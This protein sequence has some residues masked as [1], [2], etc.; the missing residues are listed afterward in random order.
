M[1]GSNCLSQLVVD[2]GNDTAVCEDV[3]V[4]RI[5]G[6]PTAKGGVPPYTY[7]WS[8]SYN[9]S[10]LVF[11]ASFMLED[12]TV[13]NPVFKERAIPESVV[14]YVTV[15]D[16]NDSVAIDSI[17]VRQTIFGACLGECRHYINLGD[18]V[19]LGH[20]VW[21]G[22]PPMHY[23]WIPTE[24]LSDSSLENPWAKPTAYITNYTLEITDSIGCQ[25]WSFCR[26]YTHTLNHQIKEEQSNIH[27]YP[28]PSSH[29]IFI[30]FN[31]TNFLNTSFE[32]NSMTGKTICIMEVYEPIISFETQDFTPGAYVYK[33]QSYNKLIE[34]GVIIIE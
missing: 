3:V 19:Q 12:T 13:A 20:C 9:I 26:V 16:A 32:I 34:T 30:E 2:A 18:S 4:L 5:G 11:T 22:I 10:Y 8:G 7:S 15:R 33:W 29:T 21:G 17:K 27:I 25:T 14:L 24:S 28:N 23:A 1:V 6:N 31:N